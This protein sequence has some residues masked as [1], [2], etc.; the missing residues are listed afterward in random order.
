M[1]TFQVFKMKVF[2]L[3]LIWLFTAK[4]VSASDAFVMKVNTGLTHNEPVAIV[5][6]GSTVDVNI[7]WGDDES[8]SFTTTSWPEKEYSAAGEYTITITGSLSEIEIGG[9]AITEIVSFGDLGLT[10][11]AGISNTDSQHDEKR[12]LVKVPDYLPPTVTSLHDLFKNTDKFN[13]PSVTKWDVSNVENMWATFYNATAFN[14][15][16]SSWNVGKVKNFDA[17][18]H[19]AETFNQDIS[20][21]DVSSAEDMRIMFSKAR[22]FNQD[23]SGWNFMN[24]K[25][26]QEFLDMSNLSLENYNS[27]L[28][29]ISEQ[30]ENHNLESIVFGAEGLHYSSGLPADARQKLIDKY[31]WIF[32]G[33]R[34]DPRLSLGI[35][36]YNACKGV[37]KYIYAEINQEVSNLLPPYKY[38]WHDGSTASSYL[39]NG[40]EAG[41]ASLTVTDAY[42]SKA[43]AGMYVPVFDFSIDLDG[44]VATDSTTINITINTEIDNPDIFTFSSTYSGYSDGDSYGQEYNLHAE[45]NR[46]KLNEANPFV[47]P[48]VSDYFSRVVTK[49]EARID[50]FTCHQVKTIYLSNNEVSGLTFILNENA[51]IAKSG[52]YCPGEEVTLTAYSPG[53]AE[54]EYKWFT[55]S[56]LGSYFEN[57]EP[58]WT[59]LVNGSDAIISSESDLLV[60]L[61]VFEDG[62]QVN[63]II[64]VYIVAYTPVFDTP[65]YNQECSSLPGGLT[66]T[67][68][69]ETDVVGVGISGILHSL[70]QNYNPVPFNGSP[71]SSLHASLWP[72]TYMLQFVQKV[73]GMDETS[74]NITCYSQEVVLQ[75]APAPTVELSFSDY[76][77]DTLNELYKAEIIVKIDGSPVEEAWMM[78]WNE[79]ETYDE[80]EIEIEGGKV[81]LEGLPKGSYKMA[82]MAGDCEYII[83]SIFEISRYRG[84][85]V[86]PAVI[87]PS[88]PGSKD[89]L[90]S[91]EIENAAGTPSVN[92]YSGEDLISENQVLQGVG[93]GTYTAKITAFNDYN[94]SETISIEVTIP[95][96]A[97]FYNGEITTSPNCLGSSPSGRAKFHA[98]TEGSIY[99]NWGT[100]F[101]SYENESPESF[102]VNGLQEGTYE[103]IIRYNDSY[104]Y[105]TIGY[106]IEGVQGPVFDGAGGRKFFC[107]GDGLELNAPEGENLNYEWSNGGEVSSIVITEE[108]SYSVTIS[109]E[110]GCTFEIPF[111]AEFY[112]AEP[113]GPGY[114]NVSPDNSS[115]VIGLDYTHAQSL[116]SFSVYNETNTLLGTVFTSESLQFTHSIQ[117]TSS[118]TYRIKASNI[119]GEEL[120]LNYGSSLYLQASAQPE[121]HKLTWQASSLDGDMLYVYTGENPNELEFLRHLSL[122]ASEFEL[123]FN[124]AKYY[125][126]EQIN[127][128][129]G[130]VYAVSNTVFVSTLPVISFSADKRI[131]SPGDTIT[132]G[133]D[134]WPAG[135]ANI[136]EFEGGTADNLSGGI[137]KVTY[138][139]PGVYNVK[140]KAANNNGADSLIEAGYITIAGIVNAPSH[141]CAGD[142]I[143]LNAMAIEGF[144]YFWGEIISNSI[145]ISPSQDTV[146]ELVSF[147]VE[148]ELELTHS[149]NIAVAQRITLPEIESFCAG[150]SLA[151]VLPEGPEYSWNGSGFSELNT[152]YIKESGAKYTLEAKD[153]YGCIWRD[154]IIAPEAKPLPVA[155]LPAERIICHSQEYILTIPATEASILW[156]DG[157]AGN[158]LAIS[159]A[160]QYCATLTLDGCETVLCTSVEY[161][162]DLEIGGLTVTSSP[163]GF[164][165]AW[166]YSSLAASYSLNSS[167]TE[168]ADNYGAGQLNAAIPSAGNHIEIT[169]TGTD[170]CGIVSQPVNLASI[171]LTVNVS[172]E[173]YANLSWAHGARLSPEQYYIFRGFEMS[174]MELLWEMPGTNTAYTDRDAQSGHLYFIA[175]YLPDGIE[176]PEAAYYGE[177]QRGY[178]VSNIGARGAG[179]APEPD[180][181]ASAYSV[182]AGSVIDFVSYAAGA[183]SLIWT[184]EGGQPGTS[185]LLNPSVTYPVPGVYSV[186][187]VATNQYGAGTVIKDTLITVTEINKDTSH[188][189]LDIKKIT[190]A[191]GTLEYSLDLADYLQNTGYSED[192]QFTAASSIS[193][194]AAD[195]EGSILKLGIKDGLSSVTIAITVTV[196]DSEA[197][198]AKNKIELVITAEPNKAPAV[199]EIPLQLQN[200]S[201]GFNALL[202]RNYVTDDYTAASQIKWEAAADDEL[203]R[204][205]IINGRLFV[206]PTSVRWT[207]AAPVELTA[208]DHQGLKGTGSAWYSYVSAYNADY[209]TA[210]NVNFRSS[211]RAVAVGTPVNLYADVL[212]ATKIRWEVEGADLAADTLPIA[213]V[214]FDKPGQYAVALIAEN[215]NGITE[216]KIE[217]YIK[218]A[219]IIERTISI[220]EGELVTINAEAPGFEQL[221]WS[222]GS[223]ENSIS[224]TPPAST[225]FTIAA[226]DNFATVHDS[227]FVNVTPALRIYGENTHVCGGRPISIGAKG[228][229]SYF[230]NGSETSGDPFI[231][232]TEPG[233][234][235]LKA[236]TEDGCEFTDEFAITGATPDPEFSFG[237]AFTVC[238]GDNAIL[239]APGFS[240]YLWSTGAET[241]TVAVFEP[242]V[243]TVTFTDE[244]GC[245]G[246]AAA[247]LEHKLAHIPS[248]GVVTKSE[249]AKNLVAWDRY[250]GYNI[251]AYRV[252]RQV[253]ATSYEMIDEVPF[254]EFSY[255]IDENSFPE[256]QSYTYRITSIDSCGTESGYSDAHTAPFLQYS[257]KGTDV[258]LKW[259]RYLIDGVERADV[260]SYIIYRGKKDGKLDSIGTVQ[261]N[262]LSFIDYGGAAHVGNVYQ[263]AVVLNKTIEPEKLKSDSGPFSQSLS[264]L[265]EAII[266]TVSA[267]TNAR[268]SLLANPVS[269]YLAAD[270]SGDASA[271]FRLITSTGII[272]AD[273]PAELLTGK[274]LYVGNLPSGIYMLEIVAGG[275]TYNFK[276]T[277]I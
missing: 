26:L 102:T 186:S 2:A 37:E 226:R 176:L 86:T 4:L 73:Y 117:V 18:F 167:S 266:S 156:S 235:V 242:G 256:K 59:P 151:V 33:D 74:Q 92:W 49:V 159:E 114:L 19:Y 132:F 138:S 210:P 43:Y 269:S 214:V 161:A 243:Y 98:E 253:T 1:K 206:L 182:E 62:E 274:G 244:H 146:I 40:L 9:N 113:V 162:P 46:L 238:P 70:P 170:T 134:I 261:K 144:E 3:F 7:D 103:L 45:S 17:M 240:S 24:V 225:Y 194:I 72:G 232:A 228:Y 105:D 109:D 275:F 177:W 188:L 136:W 149:V 140:L 237:L 236:V 34:L 75:P 130:K 257:L 66:I 121:S 254:N 168:L 65:V 198:T 112:P 155:S 69:G 123:E 83:D 20:G 251:A 30:A 229:S 141:I 108:G 122:E 127:S 195:T 79:E 164:Y 78:I 200:S 209:A 163:D 95:E 93:A 42:G 272:V 204:I 271:S 169:L 50:E 197:N 54:K 205:S 101:V 233:V 85:I 181:V 81:S 111:Y 135:T 96:T 8:E 202:L 14:Q 179:S 207:G 129:T 110:N 55:S 90:V 212:G 139:K 116:A 71:S 32:S 36:G 63:S 13:D 268:V 241:D 277:V 245:S 53:A 60:K 21:W 89:A 259:N 23:I 267:G 31:R 58:E 175:T 150:D 263:I 160:G 248:I 201:G 227:I 82:F 189:V 180:F 203:L 6:K 51:E 221:Q 171:K 145:K 77:D 264:N 88:C 217:K 273:G 184:F 191:A 84:L 219:G 222:N 119:C 224:I 166:A 56:D 35:S 211:A 265:S 187:L 216:H 143:T 172:P 255:S 183:E 57:K 68:P 218:V 215:A 252:Y 91:L 52:I 44:S 258:E 99:L 80:A 120:A 154:S 115:I 196:S 128:E 87:Q 148:L 27:L 247:E 28:I 190:V 100:E 153:S 11:I 178:A 223:T 193:D 165:A 67:F 76:F 39:H 142:S 106:T 15:D 5:L 239:A 276:V 220:C 48:E 213:T 25:Y 270:I 29:S 22:A 38:L 250:R 152:Y 246:T 133:A 16:I 118:L 137:A 41:Y 47:L 208:E 262:A 147:S 107:D 94:L 10:R 192:L 104:C 12:N 174:E 173:G 64:F 260:V 231:E 185:E 199:K 97:P 158:D 157:T 230:W 125:R 124:G 234:F 126:L 61:E 131:A 249:S